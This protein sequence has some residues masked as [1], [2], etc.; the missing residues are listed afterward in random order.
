VI[1]TVE[2]CIVG[3]QMSWKTFLFN[4]FLINYKEA[5]EKC[6]EFH[7][8]WLLILIELLAWKEL[9]ET[10]FLGVVKN[11]FLAATYVKFWHVV[12]KER[13]LDNN[14]TFY[15][16]KEVIHESINNTPCI[17]PHV[18]EAYKRIMCFKCRRHHMYI[19]AKKDQE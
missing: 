8:S 10:Q 7:Y 4:Q 5:Q 2:K 16:Y 15:V 12:H 17:L 11:N 9:E 6:I 19:Q 18:V 1:A 3:V 13:K 14:I